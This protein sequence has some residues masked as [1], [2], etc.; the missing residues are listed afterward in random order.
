MIAGVVTA[1]YSWPSFE[2]F[3]WPAK[4]CIGISFIMSLLSVRKAL[5]HS[6]VLRRLELH[7][8][9][10]R[11]KAGDQIRRELATKDGASWKPNFGLQVMWNS[12]VLYLN[13]PIMALLIGYTMAVLAA[14][15]DAGF[16]PKD[17]RT[18]VGLK[19]SWTCTLI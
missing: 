11:T 14:A 16:N 4:L 7:G 1:I 10:S 3:P 15:A 17:S 18:K 2:D 8:C 6:Y 19:T 5:K 9:D 13:I 12:S